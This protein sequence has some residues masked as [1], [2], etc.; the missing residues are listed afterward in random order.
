MYNI[1]NIGY[2]KVLYEK[3]FIES[4]VNSKE[5]T[6]FVDGNPHP[7]RIRIEEEIVMIND[8]LMI[9]TNIKYAHKLVVKRNLLKELD[10]LIM[11]YIENNT[12]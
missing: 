11:E 5:F 1:G 10:K 4:V 12:M 7:L 6:T 2:I 8:E 3:I 9:A